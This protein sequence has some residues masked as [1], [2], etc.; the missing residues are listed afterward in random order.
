VYINNAYIQYI[1]NVH[2]Q[3]LQTIKNEKPIM[4][5]INLIILLFIGILISCS[6]NES[7][8]VKTDLEL[9]T[10]K[11][12]TFD[13]FEFISS[14]NNVNNISADEIEKEANKVFQDGNVSY[15]FDS[16]KTGKWDRNNETDEF[17]WELTNDQL[18][19]DF[20]N[21]DIDTDYTMNSITE[22]ELN[23]TFNHEVVFIVQ[24]NEI[25]TKGNYYYK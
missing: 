17:N 6:E 4:K 12:W 2:I 20:L 1:N 10:E 11:K 15:Q 25:N 7:P 18:F 3:L 22:N 19:L 16:N 13:H 24:G 8:I 14:S 5:K 9:L 21:N 23:V